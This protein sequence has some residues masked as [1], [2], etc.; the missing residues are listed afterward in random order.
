MKNLFIM[1]VISVVGFSSYAKQTRFQIIND[2]TTLSKFNYTVTKNGDIIEVE[3]QGP[4][5]GVVEA[6]IKFNLTTPGVIQCTSVAN[7]I[8]RPSFCGTDSN[9]TVIDH[10]INPEKYDKAYQLLIRI[11]LRTEEAH[12][13]HTGNVVY[14]ELDLQQV[15]QAVVESFDLSNTL[16]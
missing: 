6:K 5:N 11:L 16:L 7:F 4:A 9:F 8:S 10:N 14:S 12:L 3:K 15:K 2:S 1:I 13:T